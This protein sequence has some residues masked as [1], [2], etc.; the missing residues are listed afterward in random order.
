MTPAAVC[1]VR[2]VLS[3]RRRDCAR[4]ELLRQ[5]EELVVREAGEA[6]LLPRV[7]EHVRRAR[8]VVLVL[9]EREDQVARVVEDDVAVVAAVPH[10]Q[11]VRAPV[12][13]A[14][15]HEE[16]QVVVLLHEP[17][18]RLGAHPVDR[19]LGREQLLAAAVVHVRVLDQP[20][21]PTRRLPLPQPR[22][23]PPAVLAAVLRRVHQVRQREEHPV[24]RRARRGA[25]VVQAAVVLVA[26]DPRLRERAQHLE[27]P[28]EGHA[29]VDG[30]GA[31]RWREVLEVVV[32]GGDRRRRDW[33][34]ERRRQRLERVPAARR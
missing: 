12:K 21:H 31:R 19:R 9:R 11:V 2:G 28:R 14:A 4:E 23:E 6:L 33:Q 17:E 24:G 32:A 22:E 34:H 1:C 20:V 29:L 18:L 7:G 16:R 26:L 27:P 13:L 10:H 25:A 3:E 8:V 30:V 5:H 15:A